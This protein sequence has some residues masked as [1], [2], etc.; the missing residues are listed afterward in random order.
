VTELR[1]LGPV[2]LRVAGRSVE[3]GPAKQRTVLAAL[4]VDGDEPTPTETL[5]DRVWGEAPPTA[6]RSALYSY[7]ARLR[8]VLRHAVDGGEPPWR[9]EYGAGGYR[10]A[11]P[12]DQVDLHRFRRLVALARDG[13]HGDERR[14]ALLTEARGLWHGQALADLPGEWAARTRESLDQ[15]RLDADMLWARIQLRL[16]RAG[17]TI[18]LLREAVGAHPLVEPL[19]AMLMEAL[20]REARS[21]EA[22]ECYSI[23]RRRLVD[24]LGV[25][26]GPELRRLY[27]DILQNDVD[28]RHRPDADPVRRHRTTGSADAA[29]PF[30]VPRQLPLDVH[31]FTGR[32]TEI[33]LLDSLLT[34]AAAE[35]HA[36]A[37]LVLSGGAGV[38][39][40]A[41]AVHWAHRVAGRFPD[42]Q[43]FVNLR[44]FDPAGGAMPAAEAVRVLLDALGVPAQ[45]VPVSEE[46]QIGLYRSLLAGRRVL[47]VLDNAASAEQVRPLLPGSAGSLA[48]VTSRDWLASL[49]TAEAAHPVTL[50]VLAATDARELLVARLGTARV[51]AEPV[52][53][54]EIIDRCACLPLAL[55][56]VAAR[57][58]AQ[59][60]LPLAG[61]AAELG[62]DRLKAFADT[63]PAADLRAVFSSSYRTLTGPAARLFRLLGVHPGP[64]IDT[65]AAASLA[66]VAPSTVRRHLAEL[67]RA[68][69]VTEHRTGRF[70]FHD[71]LRAYAG[72][73]AHSHD[74]VRR[75]RAAVHRVL[76]HYMHYAH[77][78]ARLMTPDREP[79][80]IAP[81]RPGVVVPAEVDA[82]IRT[83]A[84]FA[85]RRAV[86]LASLKLAARTGFDVHTWQLAW[87]FGPALD[88]GGHWRELAETNELALAAADRLG[89]RRARAYAHRTLGRARTRLGDLDAARVHFEHA[90][91][92]CA[93][94]G[95]P[96][97]QAHTHLSLGWL[98]EQQNRYREALEHARQAETL[99]AAAGHL[100]GR[101]GALNQAG[102]YHAQL[103]EYEEALAE[104]E[105]GLALQEAAGHRF[106]QAGTW[107]SM[108]LANHRLGRHR[109]AA[110]CYRR[111]LDLHRE[112]GDRHREATTLVRFGDCLAT[113]G[114]MET[115]CRQ[116][117]LA[118]RILQGLDHVDVTV[119]SARLAGAYPPVLSRDTAP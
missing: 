85:D 60:H 24:E 26:P 19:A 98:G 36:V 113:A 47:V 32:R 53:V 21:A 28:G 62:E 51:A 87:A 7:V 33:A 112:I 67:S 58:A 11:L 89:D 118:L 88:R 43:L 73:L 30:A 2:Q 76:D 116:W 1:L 105:H 38:G 79:V 35:P 55:A 48:V 22:L 16:G 97:G 57:A 107:D 75:R 8:Q 108:G 111:A 23:A 59:P 93:E 95:D 54:A 15:Q 25:E 64:D 68:H 46:S 106:G 94:I 4:L 50:D 63:D 65:E 110:E 71:L 82:S 12:V 92:L 101:G 39:K 117:E 78:M 20:L 99:Y 37:V 41:L 3:L 61:L 102:W 49:G 34:A 72:E 10:I 80:D 31:S 74:P 90:L 84:W 86:L 119:V 17:E 29:R 6:V 100:A 56:V 13:G 5:I 40:T 83:V 114:D 70:A 104:C 66:G 91:R 52:A 9:L 14:A 115:A 18:G 27:M 44:G 81:P 45:R 42:G 109:R 69:L 77:M 96:V 103:G